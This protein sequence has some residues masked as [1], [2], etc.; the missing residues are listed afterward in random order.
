MKI[1]ISFN[2][3][4]FCLMFATNVF[5]KNSNSFNEGKNL[6][7][8]KKFEE[9]KFFFEKDLVFNTKNPKSYLYLAKIYKKKE[10]IEEEEYNLQSVLLLDPK[11][12]EAIYLL[13]MLKIKQSNYEEAKDLIYNFNKVCDSFCSK[14]KDIKEK[15]S[16]LVP[17]NE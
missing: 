1:S 2:I 11:N 16:K 12:D 10:N 9:S 6:Y 3:L 13:I 4:L 15:F 7:L 5:A 8:N 14:K 17:E